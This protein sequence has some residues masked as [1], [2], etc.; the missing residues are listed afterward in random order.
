MER[1]GQRA[2]GSAGEEGEAEQRQQPA[3]GARLGHLAAWPKRSVD[4][5]VRGTTPLSF[6]R[7]SSGRIGA[8]RE[9]AETHNRFLSSCVANVGGHTG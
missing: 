1:R 3:L 7:H 6:Y 5:K 8:A 9:R 2:V 4:L